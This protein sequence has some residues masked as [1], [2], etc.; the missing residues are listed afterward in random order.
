MPLS[1]YGKAQCSLGIRHLPA[2]CDKP[3][4][5]ELVVAVNRVAIIKLSE[6]RFATAADLGDAGVRK[7]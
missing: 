4:S 5:V 7:S 3:P 1:V 6:H 2:A